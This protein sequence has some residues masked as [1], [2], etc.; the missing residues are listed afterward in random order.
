MNKHSSRSSIIERSLSP[1]DEEGMTT[2]FV[3]IWDCLLILDSLPTPFL[4]ISKFGQHFP[5]SI[6]YKLKSETKGKQVLQGR[7]PEQSYDSWPIKHTIEFAVSRWPRQVETPG[8]IFLKSCP[9]FAVPI[10]RGYFVK[11]R[12]HFGHF[13]PL[14]VTTR[15]GL[16]PHEVSCVQT[17]STTLE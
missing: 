16:K 17:C 4:K 6:N 10:L 1:N 15:C 13:T 12:S 8:T 14:K 2:W 7:P 5:L 9:G 3:Y 11:T